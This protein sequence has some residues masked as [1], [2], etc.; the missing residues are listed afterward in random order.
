MENAS[1]AL[2][3]AGGVLLTMIVASFGVYLYGVYKSHSES[4]LVRMSE[5]EISEF[6]AQFTKYEGREDLT[7]NEVVTLMN[8]VR[9]NNLTRI[10]E[11]YQIKVKLGNDGV[12]YDFHGETQSQGF[13]E[14]NG[15]TYLTN[16]DEEKFNN[17]CN[18]LLIRFSE[19]DKS[20]QRYKYTFS[21]NIK[22]YNSKTNLVNHI[23]VKCKTN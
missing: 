21:C 2:L 3:I 1:K 12:G 14:I 13:T 4:M 11:D 5:K 8:L 23:E 20:N 7:I 16:L 19:Y 22:G 9:D 6:N 15:F 18:N 17:A 10:G